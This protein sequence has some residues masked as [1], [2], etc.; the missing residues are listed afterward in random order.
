MQNQSSPTTVQLFVTCLVNAFYPDVGMATVEILQAQGLR[1]EF[2]LAQTC[3]G[4]PAFNGGFHDEARALAK[5]TIDVLAATTGPIVLPSGSCTDMIV[6]H[7]QELLGDDPGYGPKVTAVAARTTELTQFL[8]DVLGV[9]DLGAAGN[10]RLAYHHSCHGLRNLGLHDQ[11][12][13]LLDHVDGVE[14]VDLPEA[15]E[16]CGFGG[17]FAVKMGDISGAMLARKLDSVE[18]S[19]ADTLVGGDVSCLMHMAGGL[20]KR[21]SSVCVK[22]IAEVLRGKK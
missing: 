20:E 2:P 10:G 17:L 16:C 22:H 13:Q 11:A 4:Q 12:A 7:Y 19:G 1:V 6:H 15:T 5:H 3:C 9:T 14:Q 21:G 8:V 18:A